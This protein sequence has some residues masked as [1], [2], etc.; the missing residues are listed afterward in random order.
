MHALHALKEVWG[1]YHYLG[2]KMRY[3]GVKVHF[4]HDSW[5]RYKI[6]SR[7]PCNC[8]YVTKTVLKGCSH[9][10]FDWEWENGQKAVMTLSLRSSAN[11]Q[12]SDT[13]YIYMHHRARN[14]PQ[15]VFTQAPASPSQHYQ[16]QALAAV[17]HSTVRDKVTRR[18]L[19][20]WKTSLTLAA[21]LLRHYRL[22]FLAG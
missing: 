9:W 14:A 21:L 1:C 5:E 17:L 22:V 20:G 7:W 19:R 8:L 11:W 6:I 15:Y 12:T 2:V 3:L 16:H 18:Q 13:A 4:I 10:R